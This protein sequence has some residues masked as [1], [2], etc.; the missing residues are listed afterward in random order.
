MEEEEKVEEEKVEEEKVEEEEEEIEEAMRGEEEA[1]AA[2]LLLLRRSA[3]EGA[4]AAAAA[5][6][7]EEEVSFEKTEKIFSEKSL[8]GG[9]KFRFALSLSLAFSLLS[10]CLLFPL[11]SDVQAP[12]LEAPPRRRRRGHV[13]I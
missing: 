12:G 3:A 9:L 8:F 2:A 6:E 1:L 4:A 10:L 5:E 7:E 13:V 11:R